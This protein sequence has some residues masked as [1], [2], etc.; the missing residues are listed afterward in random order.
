MPRRNLPASPKPAA[1][2]VPVPGKSDVFRVHRAPTDRSAVF[3]LQRCVR[4]PIWFLSA[5]LVVFWTSPGQAE[6]SNARRQRD[7]V[8]N[9][10]LL[11]HE[12]KSRELYRQNESRAVVLIFTTT[13]CPIVQKSVTRIKALRDEF[14]SKGVVFWLVNSNTDDDA[15]SIREE[16]RDFGI[17]LPILMDRSQVVARA[18]NA[19]R[20]AEAVCIRP[21]TWTV[22]YRGA[23]DD[24]F[25]YGTEKQRASH[26][27]L[28]NALNSFLAGKKVSPARTEVKGCRI[29]LERQ[30]KK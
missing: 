9:F 8:G 12:G 27:Y 17:D 1:V 24:Q 13:G 2:E 18:L 3:R 7:E 23:I 28:E 14:G 21:K 6:S 16:A 4:V 22:F 11:D 20:T 25:G 26:N 5:L 30:E 29:Q 15:N 10:V 19:S